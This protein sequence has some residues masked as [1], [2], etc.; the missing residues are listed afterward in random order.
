MKTKFAIVALALTMTLAA[1]ISEA[2]VSSPRT[3]SHQ[4]T[5]GTVKPIASKNNKGKK[6]NVHHHAHKQKKAENK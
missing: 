5:A 2:A 3:T 1:G 6:A 4:A